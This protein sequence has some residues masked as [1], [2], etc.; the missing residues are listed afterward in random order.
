MKINSISIVPQDVGCNARCKYCI[1]HLTKDVRKGL[2][3][4][5]I[6]L[7]K[8]EK[9]FKYVTSHRCNTG[10]ITSSGETLLGSWTNIENILWLTSKYFGQLDLHTNGIEI[11]NPPDFGRDFSQMLAPYLTNVTI[12]VPHYDLKKCVE[13]GLTAVAGDYEKLFKK[14]VDLSLTIRLSCVVCKDGIHTAEDFKRYIRHFGEMGVS[15]IVFRELWAPD[16]RADEMN[17][18][19]K[20]YDWCDKNLVPQEEI[21]SMLLTLPIDKRLNW[22]GN[23][24]PYECYG[25]AVSSSTCTQ[26][27]S[28]EVVKSVV[29]RPDNFL[30]PDWDTKCRIM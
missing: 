28:K 17:P 2:K 3:K 16:L 27:F 18:E 4:P 6:N 11:L 7:P 20:I 10:I 23:G 9:C 30:Y 24:Q 12:T 14:L 1:A 29:Y 19:E 22:W 21:N 13:H 26:N 5:G 8:L 25:V 15:Q